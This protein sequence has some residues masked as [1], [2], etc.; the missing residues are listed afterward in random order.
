LNGS[1]IY[2]ETVCGGERWKNE[3]VFHLSSV[4]LF[5][6][7]T[8]NVNWQT[9]SCWN[10]LLKISGIYEYMFL[11]YTRYMSLKVTIPRRIY[12]TTK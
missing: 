12:I 2:I 5:T 6:N 10:I 8:Y 7:D 9:L 1:K 11:T 3:V 4:F